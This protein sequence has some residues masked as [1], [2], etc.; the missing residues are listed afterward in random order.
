MPSFPD[1]KSAPERRSEE[2]ESPCDGSGRTV[3][4]DGSVF[5]LNGRWRWK[6][7][8]G[9]ASPSDAAQRRGL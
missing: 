7:N 8:E 2:I 1:A 6:L 4:G 9:L 3:P 5:S